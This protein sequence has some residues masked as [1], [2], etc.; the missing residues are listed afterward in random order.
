MDSV[1]VNVL[2]SNSASTMAFLPRVEGK[3]P[4]TMDLIFDR[5]SD[6]EQVSKSTMNSSRNWLIAC[7]ASVDTRKGPISEMMAFAAR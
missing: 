3:R 7:K 6:K 2:I 4:K 1:S 5:S